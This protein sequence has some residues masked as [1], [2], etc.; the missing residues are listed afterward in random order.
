VTKGG[1][2]YN[3]FKPRRLPDRHLAV[4]LKSSPLASLPSSSPPSLLSAPLPN[5]PLPDE[6]FLSNAPLL[7]VAT[8][9]PDMRA[10]PSPALH[11]RA[12]TRPG[13]LPDSPLS[14]TTR[15]SSPTLRP[16]RPPPPRALAPSPHLRSIVVLEDRTRRAILSN[17]LST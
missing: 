14:P 12:S 1:G 9:L 13:T 6:R 7:P 11:R 10:S 16:R 17:M 3:L 5:P 15:I 2:F 4:S 8:P